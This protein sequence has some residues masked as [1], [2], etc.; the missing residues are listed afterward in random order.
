MF[1]NREAAGV[2]L[3][4][5]LQS[6]EVHRPLVLAIPR[7]GVVVGAALA[8]ELNAELD[9]ILA[10]K[11]RAPWQPEVAVG[12]ISE[13]GD[14]LMNPD[15]ERPGV[16][17]VLG[18][19]PEYTLQ[20]ID[21]QKKFIAERR[22]VYRKVRPEAEIAGRSVII[23]D[24]GLA[25]G[26]TMLAALHAV[27]AKTPK[28]IVVAVP[29]ASPDRL[30]EVAARADDC[31]CLMAPDDFHAVGAYYEDFSPISDEETV[32]VLEEAHAHV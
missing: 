30:A 25:T 27:R 9:V 4:R 7:G 26:S 16:R 24:D 28:E 21:F 29:V 22:A 32:H 17:E 10:R 23:T 19:T 1:A 5:R 2:M 12:A 31:E 6:R 11:L 8:R 20:E 14:V 15:V 18:I 13:D 3:A